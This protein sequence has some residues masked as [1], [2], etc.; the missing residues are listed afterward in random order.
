MRGCE[1]SRLHDTG[2]AASNVHGLA[3]VRATTY[4]LPGAGTDAASRLVRADRARSG[5]SATPRRARVVASIGA[6]TTT[7]PAGS[8]AIDTVARRVLRPTSKSDRGRSEGHPGIVDWIHK[9]D[10]RHPPSPHM[11]QY[12]GSRALKVRPGDELHRLGAARRE[13]QP[14]RFRPRPG[15][16]IGRAPRTCSISS[17]MWSAPRPV[18]IHAFSAMSF[19]AGEMNTSS[20]RVA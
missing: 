3:P 10:E 4:R 17:S 1:A 9:D 12:A 2:S 13:L 14:G 16:Q 19:C 20:A 8:T 18:A 5:A 11:A 7:S 6:V 15:C